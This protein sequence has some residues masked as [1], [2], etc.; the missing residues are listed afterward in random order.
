MRLNKV[1]T[2]SKMEKGNGPHSSSRNTQENAL[3]HWHTHM[4]ERRR[5]QGFL[6]GELRP[7]ASAFSVRC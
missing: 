5:Q 2:L 4:S 1:V 6:S 3:Q 7:E